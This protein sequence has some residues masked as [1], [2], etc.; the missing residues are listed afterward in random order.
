MITIQIDNTANIVN[1]GTRC[2]MLNFYR[3]LETIVHGNSYKM[4]HDLNIKSNLMYSSSF[5]HMLIEKSS[6]YGARYIYTRKQSLSVLEKT[7]MLYLSKSL[8]TYE[9]LFKKSRN[10]VEKSQSFYGKNQNSFEKKI[11]ISLKK[12]EIPLKKKIKNSFKQ[13]SKCLQ[14]KSKQL[15]I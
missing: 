6:F 15:N 2:S 9:F 4:S 14:N 13:K 7:W 3:A 8:R 5:Y 10:F 12:F 11:E 1:M